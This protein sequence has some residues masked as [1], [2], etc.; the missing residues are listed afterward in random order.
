[1]HQVR[2]CEQRRL[3]PRRP[4]AQAPVGLRGAQRAAVDPHRCLEAEGRTAPGEGGDHDE[5]HLL[6]LQS[7]ESDALPDRRSLSFSCHSPALHG[8][9]WW[10]WSCRSPTGYLGGSREC[11]LP[12]SAL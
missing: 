1:Q 4:P 7:R 6:E 8:V 3:L 12:L 2:G 5:A 10:T 9:T 11:C